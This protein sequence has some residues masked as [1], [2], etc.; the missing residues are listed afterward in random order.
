MLIAIDFDGT[1]VR[2][3]RD[4]TNEAEPLEMLP[5]VPMALAAL[6]EAEHTLILVSTRANPSRR[7]DWRLN[8]LWRDGLVPFSDERWRQMRPVWERAYERMVQYVHH[9]L[10]GMFDVVD[11]GRQGKVEADLYIDDKGMRLQRGVWAMIADTYGEVP[12]REIP[13]PPQLR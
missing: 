13:I 10:P 5:D 1:V 6:K 12:T 9:N 3:P 8:P 4:V 2:Q 7:F 11:D